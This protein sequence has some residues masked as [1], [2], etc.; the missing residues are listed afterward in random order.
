MFYMDVFLNYL[1]ER[2][3]RYATLRAYRKLLNRFAEYCGELGVSEVTAVDREQSLAFTQSLG[4]PDRLTKAT[5]QKIARLRSYFRFLEEKGLIFE[6]PLRG[7][8]PPEVPE[9]H[10]PVLTE[11][12]ITAILTHIRC[13][14]TL[15]DRARTIL[16]LAY[17]SALRPRE[18]YSLKLSDIDY[19]KGI[20]FLEQSKGRKDR[21]VPVGKRALALLHHYIDTVRPRYLK[22]KMHDYVFVNH[23][24]GEPLTVYGIRWAIQEALRRS[25]LAPIKTYSL[26]GTAATHHL[27]AGMG[28]LPI[29]KL[30]GH[31]SVRTTL[32]YLRVP[33]RELSREL[34]TKH[35][36]RRMDRSIR[37]ENQGERE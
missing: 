3:Y 17:S 29:S 18:L 22:G 15:C 35:P 9:A 6:S 27:H 16:E 28:L 13:D 34:A 2:G 4:E 20:L 5:L 10:Y 32:Y 26:R 37:R 8:A 11:A 36:R 12:Q 23:R 14:G 33:L 25:G 19:R 7:Y 31:Q 30:L 21:I 1:T 24:T